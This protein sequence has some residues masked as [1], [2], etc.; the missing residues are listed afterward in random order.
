M[1]S[2][3]RFHRGGAKNAKGYILLLP[4][5]LIPVAFFPLSG[6]NAA[7]EKLGV[8]CGPSE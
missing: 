3:N 4:E 6:E 2:K 1:I 7:N 8:L 5:G